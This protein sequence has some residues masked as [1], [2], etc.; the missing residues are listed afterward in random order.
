MEFGGVFSDEM[1]D[2]S[3]KKEH[4]FDVDYSPF[5]I[6]DPQYGILRIPDNR[7]IQVAV[8]SKDLQ[9]LDFVSKCLELDP[10]QRFGAKEAIK[11]P[12]MRDYD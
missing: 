9:F 1:I 2:Q 12:W 5:L 8:P 7:P 10:E 6:E 11:H 4:Y 3:R